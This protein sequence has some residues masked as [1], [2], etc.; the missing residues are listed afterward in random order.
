MG[1]HQRHKNG[2]NDMNRGKPVKKRLG[3]KLFQPRPVKQ[4]IVEKD[5]ENADSHGE[6]YEIIP[7]IGS[8]SEPLFLLE[9]AIDHSIRFRRPI[10]KPAGEETILIWYNIPAFPPQ[11]TA[12]ERTES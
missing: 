5:A 8:H 4:I 3:D 10:R 9:T 6:F 11:K 12:D 1:E 2:P 7:Q